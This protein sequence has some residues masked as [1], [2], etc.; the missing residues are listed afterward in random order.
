MAGKPKPKP[1]LLTVPNLL[2]LIRIILSPFIFYSLFQNTEYYT[3][4]ALILIT[5]ALITDFF[6][7]QIAR[8]FHQIS[9]WGKLLDP[10][11]DKL[12]INGIAVI[13]TITRGFPLWL[14]ITIIARDILILFLGSIMVL[15]KI[16]Y[17]PQSNNWGKTALIFIALTMLAYLI[18]WEIFIMLRLYLISGSVIFICISG[19]TYFLRFLRLESKTSSPDSGSSPDQKPF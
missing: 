15:G 4:L 8:H 18:D 13:L 3:K 5:A 6:D 9:R 2:T 19:L 16:N 10:I 17:I 11:A 12:M 14:T 7:G 1:K